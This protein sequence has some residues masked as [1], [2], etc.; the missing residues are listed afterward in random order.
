MSEEIRFTVN[1]AER[2]VRAAQNTPLVYVL[3]NDLGLR[4]TR[5]GCGVN[6]CG[7][8]HVLLDGQ[9]VPSCD[10]PLWAAAGKKV[11]T[12]EGLGTPQRAHRLQRAFVAEQAGQCAYCLSGIMISAEALLARTPDPTEAEVREALDRHLCRCGTH[13]RIVR[14]VLRAAKEAA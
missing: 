5:L 8:C 1:G 11:V 12:I 6:Q 7:A 10:T 9:S 14:A 2:A 13:N 4:G 3:R